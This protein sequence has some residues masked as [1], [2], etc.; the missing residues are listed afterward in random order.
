MVRRMGKDTV[1]FKCHHCNHCCTEVVCLPSPWD[2]KR[3]VKMVDKEPYEFLEFLEPDEI[4]GVEDDDPTWL[5]VGSKRYLM[6][7]ERHE[8]KG[9]HFLDRKTRYCSIYEARPLLCRLYPFKAQESKEGKFKGFTLHSDVGCPKHQDGVYEVKPLFDLYVQ[10][11]I[12]QEDYHELVEIFN[13]R[14]YENKEPEDF[15]TMFMDGF[16]TFL[17][18]EKND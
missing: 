5:N 10:D 12:N 18:D 17:M 7:L 8:T 6:A 2:V 14:E 15:V 9:C 16:A 13:A 1:K 3:I 4:E 11:D